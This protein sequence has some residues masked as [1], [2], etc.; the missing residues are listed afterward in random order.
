M[1]TFGWDGQSVE[2]GNDAHLTLLIKCEVPCL[3]IVRQQDK[4][5]DRPVYLISAFTQTTFSFFWN[6]FLV[7]IKSSL[8]PFTRIKK[9]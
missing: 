6:F 2:V 1:I 4:E 3:L 7:N 5:F 8:W 9:P